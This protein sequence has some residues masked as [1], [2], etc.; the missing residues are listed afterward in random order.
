MPS[1][2]PTLP[3]V[4]FTQDLHVRI[5]TIIDGERQQGRGWVDCMIDKEL[6]N[7]CPDQVDFI[8]GEMKAFV[9]AWLERVSHESGQM[10]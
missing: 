5:E 7:L 10:R 3:R 2:Q 4:L 8:L 9:I 1:L 6:V